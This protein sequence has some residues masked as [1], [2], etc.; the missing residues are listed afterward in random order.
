MNRSPDVRTFTSVIKGK[1][2]LKEINTVN[3]G[4]FSKKTENSN[5]NIFSATSR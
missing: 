1:V 4:I 3:D 2:S 5:E